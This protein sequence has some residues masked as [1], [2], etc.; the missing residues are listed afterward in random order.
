MNKF[1][2]KQHQSIVTAISVTGNEDY[3]LKYVTIVGLNKCG[4]LHS[5]SSNV[6]FI[7]S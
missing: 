6:N 1:T 7:T 4:T 2:L 3:L 5:H